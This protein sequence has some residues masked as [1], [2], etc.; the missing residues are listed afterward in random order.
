MWRVLSVAML[1]VSSPALANTTFE[2]SSHSLVS[3][4]TVIGTDVE[5]IPGT[6]LTDFMDSAESSAT[7]SG[8]S[9]ASNTTDFRYHYTSTQIRTQSETAS[10]A[11]SSDGSSFGSS[12]FTITFTLNK[13][14]FWDAGFVFQA[15]ND[16][17]AAETGQAAWQMSAS[18]EGDVTGLVFEESLDSSSGDTLVSMVLLGELEPDVYTLAVS[19]FGSAAG[20]DT[21]D[22][23][24]FLRSR[25][26]LTLN[27]EIPEPTTALL[28]GI[29]LSGLSLRHSRARALR[30]R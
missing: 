20:D 3:S 28:L 9:S 4:S 30:R 16:T 6:D 26:D 5:S 1:I 10:S 15:L 7:D 19:N 25:A 13:T 24:V 17:V 29:G 2:S 14:V 8:D 23:S 27:L 11:A 18:L 12:D 22:F 21:G